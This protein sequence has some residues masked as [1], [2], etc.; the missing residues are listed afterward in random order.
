MQIWFLCD[1]TK[2]C[3]FFSNQRI[4][5]GLKEQNGHFANIQKIG[6]VLLKIFKITKKMILTTWNHE[7]CKIHLKLLKYSLNEILKP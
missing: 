2:L 6:E 3:W 1:F 4:F 5:K 7:S